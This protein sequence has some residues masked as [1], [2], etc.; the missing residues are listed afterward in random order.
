MTTALM[1][2]PSSA[3]DP[4]LLALQRSAD[5]LD[6]AASALPTAAFQQQA[7]L[8]LLQAATTSR[9]AT[10]VQRLM[11]KWGNIFD[12]RRLVGVGVGAALLGLVA[13][14]AMAAPSPLGRTVRGAVGAAIGDVPALFAG[15]QSAAPAQSSDRERDERTTATATSSALPARSDADGQAQSRGATVST[16]ARS[17][18]EPGEAHGDV[19]S[20][21]AHSMRP[22][23]ANLAAQSSESGTGISAAT[24][25]AGADGHGDAVSSAAHPAPAG[26]N[27]GQQVS[28]AAR[29]MP[30]GTATEAATSMHE[31][32]SHGDV[33]STVAR[34]TAPAGESHGQQVS[35]VARG[36]ATSTAGA[37]PS[38]N[39]A[40]PLAGHGD[41]GND[42]GAP[43]TNHPEGS[44]KT[45]GR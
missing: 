22:S 33:V 13:V 21:A 42:G 31:A 15:G 44:G 35:D 1:T 19:V 7:R 3:G 4:V 20:T 39:T 36:S 40:S 25:T 32:A 27:H 34:T 18:L 12:R 28:S 9:P 38:V 37:L 2:S 16:I 43:L 14:P 10:P 17:T 45:H 29:R 11:T 5:L 41:K 26:E 8:A 24:A 6:R 30:I 23:T